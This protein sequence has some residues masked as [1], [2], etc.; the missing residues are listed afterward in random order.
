MNFKGQ[1]FNRGHFLVDLDQVVGDIHTAI[2]QHK[3]RQ[4]RERTDG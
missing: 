2:R 1:A 4:S 3:S